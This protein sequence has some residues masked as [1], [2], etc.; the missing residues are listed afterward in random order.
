MGSENVRLFVDDT[1]GARFGVDDNESASYITIGLDQDNWWQVVTALLHEAFEMSLYRH[2]CR[3]S[4]GPDYAADN[5]NYLFVA[6]H[7]QFSEATA[8]A[9]LFI[10][11]CLPRLEEEYKKF[12]K[13]KK[14]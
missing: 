5:G 14:K 7:T 13:K 1:Y 3:Y 12:H 9:A 11:N 10:A 6:T 4:Q 8:R 2:S